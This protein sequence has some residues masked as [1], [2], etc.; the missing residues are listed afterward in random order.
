MNVTDT[1]SALQT[2]RGGWPKLARDAG[3]SYSWL[4]KFAGGK[5]GDPRIKT[6]TAIQ[7]ALRADES[8]QG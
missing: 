2:R 1:I 5:I 6:L 7:R 8:G 4:V 3:V